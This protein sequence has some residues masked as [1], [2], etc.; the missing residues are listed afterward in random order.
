MERVLSAMP[1]PKRRPV[2]KKPAE[3]VSPP[4]EEEKKA[5]GS[6]KPKKKIVR[7]AAPKEPAKPPPPDPIPRVT[8]VHSVISGET[9]WKNLHDIFSKTSAGVVTTTKYDERS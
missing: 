1:A 8:D 5:D 6:P 7:K 2:K 9:A 4:P 3:A